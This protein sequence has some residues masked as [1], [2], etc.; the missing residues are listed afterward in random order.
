MNRPSRS[1]VTPAPTGGKEVGRG[2]KKE[3]EGSSDKFRPHM[4]LGLC[5]IPPVLVNK[6]YGAEFTPRT[7]M[8]NTASPGRG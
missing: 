6:E 5:A 8:T 4:K 7:S 2:L 3:I 1:V